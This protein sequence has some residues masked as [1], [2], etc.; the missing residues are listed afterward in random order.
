MAADHNLRASKMVCILDSN[1][2]YYHQYGFHQLHKGN[3]THT[4]IHTFP[5][6]S[7]PVE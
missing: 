1:V 2:T 4:H 6:F 5:L 3:E 7:S